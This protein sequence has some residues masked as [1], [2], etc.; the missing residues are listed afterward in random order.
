MTVGKSERSGV[1]NGSSVDQ[2]SVVDDGCGVVRR[3]VMR[4]R[5]VRGSVVAHD[6]LRR[7]GRV[8]ER[9]QTCVGGG[10]HGAEGYYL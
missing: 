4:G 7:D 5:V 1:D 3:R 2:R 10:Q 6:A 9:E 8:V